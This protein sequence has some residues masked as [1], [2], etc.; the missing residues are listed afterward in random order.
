[1]NNA[2]KNNSFIFETQVGNPGR[3]G[4]VVVKTV[5]KE[6]KAVRERVV[7]KTAM[8]QRRRRERAT[9]M[10]AMVSETSVF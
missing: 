8:A 2:I 7:P 4:A 9:N 5:V 1:M 10:S 6:I 3:A